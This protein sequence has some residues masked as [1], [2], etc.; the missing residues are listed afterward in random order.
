[1]C[2]YPAGNGRTKS[3]YDVAEQKMEKM[4]NVLILV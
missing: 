3:F 4:S 1:V 2:M